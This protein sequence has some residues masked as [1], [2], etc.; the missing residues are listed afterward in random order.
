MDA[1]VVVI[2][3]GGV[4]GYFGFKLAKRY[5]AEKSVDI[6]FVTR[7]A[8]SKRR[9]EQGLRLL[10]REHEYS[11]VRHDHLLSNVRELSH[12]DRLLLCVQDYDLEKLCHQLQGKIT[13]QSVLLPLMN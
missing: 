4:G 1:K 3:L 8:T 6:T 2:G 5:E 7:E 9:K 11:T 12:I 10:S 13:P